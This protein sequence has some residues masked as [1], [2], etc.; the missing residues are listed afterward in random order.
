MELSERNLVTDG[1]PLPGAAITPLFPAGEHGV[2]NTLF[3][4]ALSSYWHQ[5]KWSPT[6]TSHMASDS[7]VA[8]TSLRSAAGTRRADN[9]A[10]PANVSPSRGVNDT[11]SPRPSS[12]DTSADS[13]ASASS[14]ASPATA[15]AKS[16]TT[17]AATSARDS[18]R[19]DRSIAAESSDAEGTERRRDISS[20]GSSTDDPL[21]PHTSESETPPQPAEINQAHG[22]SSPAQ[23][24]AAGEIAYTPTTFPKPKILTAALVLTSQTPAVESHETQTKTVLESTPGQAGTE[25]DAWLYTPLS[26]D[27]GGV[28]ENQHA[29]PVMTSLAP[30]APPENQPHHEEPSRR[31]PSTNWAIAWLLPSTAPTATAPI[32]VTPPRESSL[33]SED[34]AENVAV[35]GT[36]VSTTTHPSSLT[37]AIALPTVV[38]RQEPPQHLGTVSAVTL[39]PPAESIL[40][41]NASQES[42]G[43]EE[44]STQG[45]T[46]PAHIA[47]L[48]SCTAP[49]S[50][51]RTPDTM[52]SDETGG[53]APVVQ[54]SSI[55][56]SPAPRHARL[57]AQGS[58]KDET[59][60]VSNLSPGVPTMRLQ[61]SIHHAAATTQPLSV[62]RP[63][64][65]VQRLTEM[66][67]PPFNTPQ[68]LWMRL[69]PPELGPLTIWV[70]QQADG[71][72]ARLE[73]TNP[74]AQQALAEQLPL[75]QESLQQRGHRVDRLDLV[76]TQDPT[77]YTG[78]SSQQF[79]SHQPPMQPHVQHR[80]RAAN[81]SARATVAPTPP[82]QSPGVLNIR[83]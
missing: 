1:I 81:P 73:T 35:P 55:D 6:K 38:S 32:E 24:D 25:D 65:L 7:A 9:L 47:G 36:S 43:S 4:Q 52:S 82:E 18:S 53:T 2:E 3:W 51:K 14:S 77:A 57:L 30:L 68:P 27:G 70:S 42:T 46:L 20:V 66:L 16:T 59:P 54:A 26:P 22:E 13:S 15:V 67:T 23:S 49:T 12:A 28:V 56:E 33:T 64:E 29:L 45:T 8:G 34:G 17:S 80:E 11:T 48:P 75:L 21:G 74:L 69:D 31:Q 76:L 50:L 40:P 63:H 41:D 58:T 83:I 44:T 79:T 72:V 62:H 71:I 19:D 60:G 78:G 37:A 10:T 39:P 61:E 5:P